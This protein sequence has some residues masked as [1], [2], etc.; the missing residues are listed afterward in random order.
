MYHYYYYYTSTKDFRAHPDFYAGQMTTDM[1][2][3]QK[4]SKKFMREMKDHLDWYAIC[5]YQK[6]DEDFI[7][8]MKDYIKWDT[9]CKYNTKT[10]LTKDFIEEHEDLVNWDGISGYNTL[11]KEFILKHI[12]K[13][14][15]NKIFGNHQ[16]INLHTIEILTEFLRSR[17]DN[18]FGCWWNL[19]EENID[20]EFFRE[21]KNQIKFNAFFSILSIYNKLEKLTDEFHNDFTEGDW[22]CLEAYLYQ[23]DFD[24]IMKYSDKWPYSKYRN[25][26]NY[27]RTNFEPWQKEIIN[28][29]WKVH[30]SE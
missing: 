29:L 21:F 28:N 5:T 6:L 16:T 13:L 10:I 24:F 2:R 15:I 20:F 26:V 3:R 12:D 30:N 18:N 19:K 25:P 11:N 17:K 8:E 22:S 14:N 7:D 1:C 23:F 9:L 4:L 27:L